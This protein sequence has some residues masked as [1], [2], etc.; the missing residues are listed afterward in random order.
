MV[1]HYGFD[2]HFPDDK[3]YWTPSHVYFFAICMSSLGKKK[4]NSLFRAFVWAQ[5]LSPAWLCV[6][7]NYSLP[8][9]SVH[10]ISKARI[11]KWVAISSSRDSAQPRDQ[12]HVSLAGGFFTTEPPGKLV[13]VLCP[14]LS[15][16]LLF[17]YQVLE[18][19]C[20]FWILTPFHLYG[21]QI[22]SSAAQ[23]DFSFC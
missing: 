18:V 2:L 22:L 20:T 8:G 11:L 1:S 4:N 16:H 5:S 6:P 23:V 10:G 14:F 19:P 12:T 13:Q 3:Q 15:H 17:Y 9:S 7:M 21:S